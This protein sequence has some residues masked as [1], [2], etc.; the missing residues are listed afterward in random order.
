[1]KQ[2][3]Q[4]TAKHTLI[5]SIGDIAQKAVA[6]FLLPVYMRCLSPEDYGV[7]SIL[8]I[9]SMVFS[10]LI[11]QALPT[12]SFRFYS[13]DHGED[14]R[15]RLDVISTTYMYLLICSL[16]LYTVLFALSPSL[17]ALF[18]KEGNFSNFIR[19][20]LVTDF[21]NCASNIPFVI[22]RARLLSGWAAGIALCRVL[23][24]TCLI[25]W[26]VVVRDMGIV[27]VLYANLI[28][29]G[30][31][32]L[33]AP[34]ITVVVH[35]TL[36]FHISVDK[37]KRMLAFGLPIVPGMFAGWI[38][39]SADRYFLEHFSTRSQLG[40]Y[41]IGFSFASILS[42]AFVEPFRKTWPAIFYPKAKEGDAGEVFSR[43]VTYFMLVGFIGALAI[44][45][46]SEHLILL[47][48]PEDYWNA[49]NVVP[50]LV[51]GILVHGTQTTVNMGLFI[52]NKTIYA[53]LIVIAAALS[54]IVLNALLIPKFGMM[55]AA[56]GTLLSYLIMLAITVEVNQRL[57]PIEYEYARLLHLMVLFVAI[58]SL[59]YTFRFDFWAS[60]FFRIALF[61]SFFLLLFVTRFFTKSEA[62]AITEVVRKILS[63]RTKAFIRTRPKNP[64]SVNEKSG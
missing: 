64:S 6:F 30:A 26:F 43:F 19:I 14:D 38:M 47:M 54:N 4:T 35:R 42:F 34:L 16:L 62:S 17:S 63:M 25:I 61:S 1:M 24:G 22:L 58:V 51:T 5:F 12:A 31:I 23:V 57:Y 9:M 33:L 3:L 56:T 48:G 45:C 28:M 53:P 13:F 11:L 55:G 8:G 46:C 50:I 52:K 10:G 21:L 44:I 60:L 20:V 18:F 39:Q 15:E 32:F 36:S 40:L 2:F 37:L 29:G 59:N 7:L 49:Y 27:G 41:S